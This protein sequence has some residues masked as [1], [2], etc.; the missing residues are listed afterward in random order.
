LSAV[1][2]VETDGPSST[3]YAWPMQVAQWIGAAK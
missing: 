3:A 1:W 2:C